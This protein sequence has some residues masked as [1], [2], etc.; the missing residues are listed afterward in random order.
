MSR[1]GLSLLVAMACLTTTPLLAQDPAPRPPVTAQPGPR[2]EAGFPSY[3][4]TVAPQQESAATAAAEHIS[5]TASTLGL[6]LLIVLVI[7]LL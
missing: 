2:L 1:N 4:A 3:Q 6:V 7:V 5:I